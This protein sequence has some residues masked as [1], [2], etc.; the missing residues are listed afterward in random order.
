MSVVQ[1]PVGLELV[2]EI[3]LGSFRAW[4]I[5]MLGGIVGL[6]QSLIDAVNDPATEL[7]PLMSTMLPGDQLW[8]C[9]SAMRGPLF[10][11]EGV[12]V[13]RQMR[14]IAYLRKWNY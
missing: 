13:V 8:R 3:S 14:P 10:G 6:P 4:N 1:D 2:E 12:A 5:E 9:R 7:A 11:H